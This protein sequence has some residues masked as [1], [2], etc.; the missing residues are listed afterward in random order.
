MFHE[1]FS[2]HPP[3]PLSFCHQSIMARHVRPPILLYKRWARPRFFSS[4]GTWSHLFAQRHSCSVPSKGL[5]HLW[6]L[7]GAR[8]E[9]HA[10]VSYYRLVRVRF[11][12]SPTGDLH[13]GGLRT[14]LINYLV[15]KVCYRTEILGVD[16]VISWL[17]AYR[18]ACTGQA[19]WLLTL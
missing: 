5:I 3:R 17:L 16:D 1:T 18:D 6:K 2:G 11:A 15:A 9:S 4:E 12:P 8:F 14:A 13:L 19:R 10:C 7:T